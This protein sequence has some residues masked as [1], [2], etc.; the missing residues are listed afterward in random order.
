MTLTTIN[1]CVL[2]QLASFRTWVALTV[3]VISTESL[4]FWEQPEGQ[5]GL[6]VQDGKRNLFLLHLSQRAVVRMKVIT[7]ENIVPFYLQ[8]FPSGIRFWFIW[9]SQVLTYYPVVFPGLQIPP[10]VVYTTFQ[11]WKMSNICLK[12]PKQI[13]V[14]IVPY[15][16]HP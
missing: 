1:Y 11:N 8:V 2:E 5:W 10:Y 4:Q 14:L 3:Q 12:G 15:V 16:S 9:T 6:T 13:K 7:K